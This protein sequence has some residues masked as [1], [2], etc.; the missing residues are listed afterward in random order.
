M[1]A[2]QSPPRANPFSKSGTHTPATTTTI[3]I[4]TNSVATTTASNIIAASVDERPADVV[5]GGI[6]DVGGAEDVAEAVGNESIATAAV[7][8]RGA[9]PCFDFV[10][11]VALFPGAI[12]VTVSVNMCVGLH[13]SVCTCVHGW[14]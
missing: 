8:N 13:A 11:P 6:S 9:R 7:Q 2:P 5:H 1:N 4:A 3:G 12:D 10:P 14:M